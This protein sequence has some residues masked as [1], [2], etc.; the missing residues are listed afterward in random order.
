MPATG[1]AGLQASVLAVIN[2]VGGI[3]P[4]RSMLAALEA[5]P[6]LTFETREYTGGRGPM[7]QHLGPLVAPL[8]HEQLWPGILTWIKTS[9]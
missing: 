4:P 3:V 2:P 6:G 5:A 7:L 9:Q 1:I 8:A